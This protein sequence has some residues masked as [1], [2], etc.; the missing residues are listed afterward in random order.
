LLSDYDL[1][2][3]KKISDEIESFDLSSIQLAPTKES[4]HVTFWVPAE[5]KAKY[6]KIQE[7]SRRQFGKFLR[8][9]LMRSIDQVKV[10]E[11][12]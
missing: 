6:D 3:N 9:V 1:T 8:G 4:A 10:D 2:M 12:I 7:L 11:A 5:Y